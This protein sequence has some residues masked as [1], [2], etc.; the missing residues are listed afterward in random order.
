MLCATLVTDG[1]NRV[2]PLRPEFISP[3][4]GSD[5]Q[6][7]ELN[8]G[9]RWLRQNMQRY[10]HL[11]PIYLADDLFAHQPFCQERLA[12]GGDFLFTAKQS[13]LPTLY[14]YLSGL[15]LK[16]KFTLNLIAFAFHTV[17]DQVCALW[18]QARNRIS[19]R[20]RFFTTL[21][22][23]TTTSTLPTGNNY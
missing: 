16:R 2:V 8:A 12:L 21:M 7:C 3:Q 13:S 15:Q 9:K 11:R 6:N 18:H 23:L 20:Q 17:C 14:D 19:R 1:H 4:D 5:K 10:Q 22:V